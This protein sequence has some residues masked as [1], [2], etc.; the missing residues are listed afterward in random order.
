M[1]RYNAI[2]LRKDIVRIRK[3]STLTTKGK[4]IILKSIGSLKRYRIL[5]LRKESKLYSKNLTKL[6]KRKKRS[7]TTLNPRLTTRT[8]ITRFTKAIRKDPDSSR[9]SY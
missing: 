4:G 2:N 1:I 9:K 7:L 6:S 5:S 8:T 3:G